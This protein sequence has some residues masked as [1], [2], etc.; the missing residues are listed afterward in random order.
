MKLE[1]VCAMGYSAELLDHFQHPR[2]VGELPAPNVSVQV[3]NPACGDIMQLSL[4]ISDGLIVQSR[5]RTKGCV[6]AIAC[7]SLLT[8]LICGRTV[9]QARVLRREQLV[10]TLGLPNESQHASHLACDALAAALK[11]LPASS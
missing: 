9:S 10:E 5:F 2:N 8:E 6:A 4:E 1:F 3:E 11:K 7:G